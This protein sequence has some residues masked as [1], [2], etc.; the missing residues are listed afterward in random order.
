MSLHAHAAR[1]RVPTSTV[2]T[3]TGVG[4]ALPRGYRQLEGEV[5]SL[6]IGPSDMD[7]VSGGGGVVAPSRAKHACPFDST[8]PL[9]V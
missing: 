5:S 9:R 3:G 1:R 4:M 2:A 7:V 8:H 6:A